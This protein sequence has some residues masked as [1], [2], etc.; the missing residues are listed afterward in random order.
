MTDRPPLEL[1]DAQARAILDALPGCVLLVEPDLRLAWWNRTAGDLF[2]WT[3]QPPHGH[4]LDELY[5]DPADGRNLALA[6][7][8]AFPGVTTARALRTVDGARRVCLVQAV[9]VGARVAL[10]VRDTDGGDGAVEL[11]MRA[12]AG[13]RGVVERW[14]HVGCIHSR[15]R[16]VYA[17]RALCDAWRGP[18][19][20]LVGSPVV[21]LVAPA[22]REMVAARVRDLYSG[23]SVEPYAE[24]TLLRRDGSTFVAQVGALP[25]FYDGQPSVLVWAIDQT[26]PRRLKARLDQADRMVALGTLAAG[27]A[28]EIGNPLTYMLL[29]LDAAQLRL[30]ELRRSLAGKPEAARVAAATLDDLGGHLAAVVD[31]ARRVRSIVGDLKLFSRA[32]DRPAVLDVT[33]PLERALT[34]AHHELRD[35]AVERDY[36]PTPSV[37]ASDARLTQVFVNLI[38]NAIHA[39][40]APGAGPGPHRVRLEV[41]A[42]GGKVGVAVIDSGCGIEPADLPHIFDPFYTSKAP[43]DGVGLGLAISRSIVASLAGDIRVESQPGL[44]S[45]FTV[46][47]PAV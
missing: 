24:E 30:G 35:V 2:G 37:M 15:G 12:D 3:G 9:P 40:R 31:G 19:E 14:P 33:A 22:D 44:G 38:L 34:M 45:R 43:G 6:D 25:I 32:D 7:R 39:T 4:T 47:L 21:E 42:E 17:N 41:A 1:S 29:R 8:A 11:L 13:L 5:W 26:E 18:R 16:V 28:H 27:V 23:A 10:L 36:R 46:V 20:A